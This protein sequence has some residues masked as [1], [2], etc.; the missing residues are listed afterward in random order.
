M[1]TRGFVSIP[2]FGLV[3]YP[4]VKRDEWDL[5]VIIPTRNEAGNIEK[6]LIRIQD[7]LSETPIEVI[8]ID[9][10]LDDTPQVIRTA[11]KKFPKLHVRLIH[12]P[13]GRRRGGLGGAV[14]V[15]LKA[16][17]SEYACV[18]DGD[19]QHPPEKLPDLLHTAVETHADLVVASRR[20]QESQMR[21][22]NK[23]RNMVSLGLD[24]LARFFFPGKLQGISD[25]LTGF[26]L[27]RLH[28]IDL[29]SLHPNGFKILMEILIR[30][31]EMR[32]AEVPFSFEK[33]FAGDSKA[34]VEEAWRY[35][36]LLLSLRFG[37]KGSRLI[38]FT[39]VGLSGI[40]I[41][42]LCM[43]ITTG[44]LGIFYLVSTTIATLISSLWNF[45]LTEK[46]IYP[47]KNIAAGKGS[48]LIFFLMI[49]TLALILRIPMIYQMT[50]AMGFHYL[51]SNLIS[52][53]ILAVM[54]YATPDNLIWRSKVDLI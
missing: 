23:L 40:L 18:M 50:G 3:E 21:G 1:T 17:R 38:I 49:N 29:D 9:D 45:F 36:N 6:L 12:R 48:R 4:R 53:L 8:F 54:R 37:D 5:S 44:F 39:A 13:S 10:S 7:A 41:N 26:F 27:V 16:A 25:P 19:L 22:L 35:L 15:G 51:I 11:I 34:S 47:S 2:T 42:T 28:A 24:L 32:K 46:L 14:I 33:R 20:N 31:P 43:Y 52:L 30:N